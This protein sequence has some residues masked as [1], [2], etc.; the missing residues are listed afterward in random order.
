MKRWK[1]LRWPILLALALGIIGCSQQPEG[2][3]GTMGPKLI[4]SQAGK[5]TAIQIL[6]ENPRTDSTLEAEVNFRG[7]EPEQLGYQWL[8]N[9][10]II[11]GAIRRTLGSQHLHKGDFIS[12]VIR[13]YQ[14]GGSEQE[15]TSD[16]VI[17]GNTVPVATFASVEPGTPKSNDTLK[18]VAAAYDYDGD[19]VSFSYQWMVNGEPIVGEDEQLLSGQHFRRGDRVQVAVIPFDGEEWGTAIRSAA[20]VAQNSPPKIVSDPPARTEKGVFR[21]AVK[22]EDPDED[23]LRFSL[24]GKP[25]SGLEID[26]ATGLVQW[27]VVIPKGEITYVFQVVAEDPDGGQSIQEITLKYGSGA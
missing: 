27:Q 10:N 2:S 3:R 13:V 7:W 24:R 16:A 12:V 23:T 15:A 5:I 22:A 1:M 14:P 6:P 4:S 8:R 20:V 9:G 25:P 19:E 17:I 18:V 26:A 11:P 21:Y